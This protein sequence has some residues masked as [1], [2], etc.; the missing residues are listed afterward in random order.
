MTRAEDFVLWMN[1]VAD[2][3]GS[4]PTPEQWA[5]ITDE[6]HTTLGKMAEQRLT[7]SRP[8]TPAFPIRPPGV[9]STQIEHAK[10]HPAWAGSTP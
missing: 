4:A 10:A 2:M 6:M 5:R 7:L 1:G 3:V 8:E 9:R